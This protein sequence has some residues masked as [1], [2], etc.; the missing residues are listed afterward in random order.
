MRRHAL[1]LVVL[2]L[3]APA[4][5]GTQDSF[6]QLVVRELSAFAAGMSADAWLRAHPSDS[7]VSF[8]DSLTRDTRTWCVRATAW[9][10]LP[11]GRRAARIAYFFPPPPP[12]DLA[13]PTVPVGPALQR[14]GCRLGGIWIGVPGTSADT[15]L[16]GQVRLAL[17]KSLGAEAPLP[18]SLFGRPIPERLRRYVLESGMDL[19]LEDMGLSGS[20]S[21]RVVGVWRHDSVETISA[22]DAETGGRAG[23][24]IALSMAGRNHFGPDLSDA[25]EDVGTLR[26]D[27]GRVAA[28]LH[29]AGVDAPL[30]AG[31][32][33][34]MGRALA[35]Y[36]SRA[37]SPGPPSATWVLPVLHRLVTA[38]RTF[39][40]RRRSAALLA[41]D[42]TLGARGV[43][44]SVAS[45]SD[46]TARRVLGNLG[47]EFVHSELGASYNY[48][49]S[50]LSAARD[51]DPSGEVARLATIL[52]LERGFNDNGICGGG[53]EAFRT[54]T[55]VG[56]TLLTHLPDSLAAEVHLLVARGYADIVELAANSDL[57]EYF[58]RQK[59]QGE[60]ASARASAI[61]HYR[62]GLALDHS[63]VMARA[64]WREAWRLLA[65]LPPGTIH[66]A[67]VYD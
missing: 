66:F 45:D 26:R 49:H 29:M 14:Q 24:M 46:S 28:L 35:W 44:N 8:V 62:R 1:A 65:G 53:A 64:S 58:D 21:W 10:T 41:A 15:V 63:S 48:T 60:A 33:G 6:P 34:I 22:Y 67:C 32:R 5:R 36:D 38:A 4:A 55:S 17:T 16:A 11:D 12:A 20:A 40:G 42:M 51:A 54:V 37:G 7:V 39:D 2:V 50:W 57:A 13:L 9:L 43:E 30:A 25:A 59:Y 18:D 19:R 47:A 27:S 3:V 23:G 31:V 61:A 56:E 52:E